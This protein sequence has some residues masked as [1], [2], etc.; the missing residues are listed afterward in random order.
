MTLR[1]KIT[2]LLLILPPVIAMPEL[3]LAGPVST[4]FELK[5]YSFGGGGDSASS[6]NFKAFMTL[7]EISSASLSSQT[8]NIGSGLT[9]TTNAN[10]PPAPTL[11]NPSS[12]YDRLKFV[13]NT[14]SNPSDVTFA[15]QISTDSTFLTD[16]KYIKAD[17]S[18]GTTLTT[19]DFQT[20]T[21]WGGVSGAYVTGLSQGTT[22]YVRAK[23]RQGSTDYQETQ[24]GPISSGVTTS[25]PTL[26]FSISSSTVTFNN[27]NGGNSY[28]DATQ[29]TVLTTST[30]AYNGYV[31]N[32]R[33]TAALTHI[34][35]LSTTITDYTGT[36][37]TPTT[38]TGNGFG[39]TT[40]DNDLSGGTTT[41]FGSGTKYAGFTTSSPGDPVADHAGPVTTAI[42]NETFTVSYKIAATSTQKAGT[43]QTTIL[44]N[45]VPEY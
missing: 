42:S 17:N 5:S 20:Y 39:Y 13:V 33:E 43:Y 38:W 45:N 4:N 21:T 10:T 18:I 41:R 40:S 12:N 44:Y 26:T 31:I 37:A 11:T 24:W 23:A 15:I 22:Y 3:V 14:S 1:Q 34:G 9:Y 32:A 27:L 30:N 16:V 8:F 29:T 2:V 6:S 25:A 19:T 7:G 35:D 28:T 36:N